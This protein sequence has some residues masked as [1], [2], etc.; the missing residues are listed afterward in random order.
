MSGNAQNEL[1]EVGQI[2]D[3]TMAV[4]R[5]MV[6]VARKMTKQARQS[7][8]G[9]PTAD[10]SRVLEQMIFIP[11]EEKV[12]MPVVSGRE[13]GERKAEEIIICVD[14]S[15][16]PAYPDW[17]KDVLHPELEKTGPA[18]YGLAQ[19]EQ[20]LHDLQKNGGSCTG[21]NVFDHLT[22]SNLLDSH[23][24]LAD[25]L[26]IQKLGIKTF[27]KFFKGKVVYFWRSVVRSCD[28]H[29]DVPAL[30]ESGGKVVLRW[31]WLDGYWDGYEPALRLANSASTSTP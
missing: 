3:L 24:G 22:S 6:P 27:R 25:A 15:I 4:Q 16:R 14:R 30:R 21:Q 31:P 28:G 20:W 17:V 2:L 12:V 19:V 29:L 7:W 1:D 23:L 11:T 8:I 18:E 9:L 13:T 26:A 5:A 10:F